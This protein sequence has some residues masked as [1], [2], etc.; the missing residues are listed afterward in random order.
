M[1]NIR[2][3]IADEND[4][5]RRMLKK[6]MADLP[7]MMIVGETESASALMDLIAREQPHLLLIDPSQCEI[8]GIAEL[9]ECLQNV[10]H[11]KM[12]WMAPHGDFATEAFDL[13]VADYL[14]KPI[15]R[16]RLYKALDR[17]KR[18]LNMERKL[19][20]LIEIPEKFIVKINTNLHIIAYNEVLFIEKMG[21][22]SIVHTMHNDPLETYDKLAPMKLVQAHRSYLINLNRVTRIVKMGE[23]YQV[24]FGNYPRQALIAKSKMKDIQELLL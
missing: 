17:T 19:D 5:T 11:L 14:I 24:F 1:E 16:S 6:Y 23:T 4:Q 12:I 3:I 9:K 7:Y 21:K 10:S 22:K 2:V 13:G 15:G 20:C 18:M 8:D